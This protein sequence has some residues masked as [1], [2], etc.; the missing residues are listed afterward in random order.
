[1]KL[2]SL[3]AVALVAVLSSPL[4]SFG[5]GTGKDPLSF[6]PDPVAVVG[7]QKIS[8]E[9]LVKAVSAQTRDAGSFG[10]TLTEQQLKLMCKRMTDELIKAIVLQKLAADAGFKPTAE[11]GEQE[12]QRISVDFE[13]NLPGQKYADVLK[14]QGLDLAMVKRNMAESRAIDLWADN[15]VKPEMDVKEETIE[16]FYKE[17]KD[18][19]F[20]TPEAFRVSHVLI[21]PARPGDPAS[22]KA[23]QEKAEDVRKK[24]AD[25]ADFAI[26]AARFSVCPSGKK[27][28]GDLGFKGRGE[29]LESFAQ[30]VVPLKEGELSPVV[31]TTVG[32]HVIK[33]TG[34]QPESYRDLKEVHDQIKEHLLKLKLAETIRKKIEEERAKLKPKNYMSD[35]T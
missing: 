18:E 2:R 22:E 3:G 19:Y 26:M 32:Y 16:A 24:L 5:A 1:M 9:R 33:K 15:S 13:K 14:Q 23:A 25:G 35:V 7:D 10:Q 29:M 28:G 11:L 8:R 30:A 17:K 27:S 34:H 31:K 20:K 12:F 4:A 21:R 6:V